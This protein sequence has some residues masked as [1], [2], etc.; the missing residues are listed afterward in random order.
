MS[1]NFFSTRIRTLEACIEPGCKIIQKKYPHIA[2]SISII[3][4][5]LQHFQEKEKTTL[6][7]SNILS[8]II[9]PFAS[10]VDI[11]NRRR[12]ILSRIQNDIR[13]EN[14]TPLPDQDNPETTAEIV[15]FLTHSEE[16]SFRIL[17]RSLAINIVLIIILFA[18]PIVSNRYFKQTSET[19]EIIQFIIETA[20]IIMEGAIYQRSIQQL[21]NIRN[22]NDDFITHM[23]HQNIESN[24]SSGSDISDNS[25][26][27]NHLAESN[28]NHSSLSSSSSQ[29]TPST[30]ASLDSNL[31]REFSY[32]SANSESSHGSRDHLSSE[33]GKILARN[34]HNEQ[35]PTKKNTSENKNHSPIS[36]AN[37]CGHFS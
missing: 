13:N 22:Q 19:K 24:R 15:R 1:L 20:V 9:G 30:S 32:S 5:A 17:G 27:S 10:I 26:Y 7:V 3:F 36:V 34:L 21:R 31:V 37:L 16:E 25:V 4:L 8:I 35:S 11:F 28:S 23:R 14:Y 18:E 2:L 6:S 29:R 12:K 33:C